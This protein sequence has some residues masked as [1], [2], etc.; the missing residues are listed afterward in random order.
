M[1]HL[2]L[3]CLIHTSVLHVAG[4]HMITPVGNDRYT[5][6]QREENEATP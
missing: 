2:S 4:V 5:C 6:L 1:G 3:F